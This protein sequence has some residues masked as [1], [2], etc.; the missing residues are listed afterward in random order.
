MAL[1]VVFFGTPAFAV[2]S[3]EALANSSHQIVAAVTQP[4]RPRG[5]GQHV[6][7]SPVKT[8]A[9]ARSIPVLQPER[10]R[11]AAFL[12]EVA[13][14][15]PDLSVV[16]AYGRILPVELIEQP[17]LGTINV[18]ASL[19]PRWRG[20]AP[21]HRAVM[22][23]DPMTGITIMRVV[24]ALDAGPMLARRETPIAI[25]ETSAT[26]EARLAAIGAGLLRE[27]VDALARGP[28]AETPQDPAG[29]TYA[30]KLERADSAITFDQPALALHNAIRGLQPWPLASAVLHGKRLRL[31]QSD[32]PTERTSNADPGTVVGVEPD[33]LIVAA[34]GGA[35]AITRVQ[36]EGRPAIGVRDFLNGHAVRV[37]DR[38]EPW[39]PNA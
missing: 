16:A 23:G 21:V 35:L 39:L 5:R 11:D 37:G 4:D 36:L 13:A 38:F 2:P 33:R 31:L 28:V 15:S 1:R 14:L 25:D 8:A 10:P 32:P 6:T 17:R 19:L 34:R 24:Q 29:V 26:L 12:R 27:T 9:V 7:A 20:A 22:A 30:G 3:L 18:H